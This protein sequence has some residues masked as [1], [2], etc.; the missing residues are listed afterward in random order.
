MENVFENECVDW[1]SFHTNTLGERHAK[2]KFHCD[3]MKFSI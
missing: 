2:A 3:Y 1:H